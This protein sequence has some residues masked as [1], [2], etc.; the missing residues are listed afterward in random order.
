MNFIYGTPR[1]TLERLYRQP[2]TQLFNTD[3]L[4]ALSAPSGQFTTPIFE[5]I[6]ED[7]IRFAD[8]ALLAMHENSLNLSTLDK[9]SLERSADPEIHSDVEFYHLAHENHMMSSATLEAL[10]KMVTKG[11]KFSSS[12]IAK[13]MMKLLNEKQLKLSKNG[14]LMNPESLKLFR[15]N[16]E[17]IESL[18]I[19]NYEKAIRKLELHNLEAQIQIAADDAMVKSGI[20]LI[21]YALDLIGEVADESE[22]H[23][24]QV[25][26]KLAQYSKLTNDFQLDDMETQLIA[27]GLAEEISSF[28]FVDDT[29]STSSKQNSLIKTLSHPAII[30]SLRNGHI[31]SVSNLITAFNQNQSIDWTDQNNILTQLKLKPITINLLNIAADSKDLTPAQAQNISSLAASVLLTDG[32]SQL[33]AKL[34]GHELISPLLREKDIP[35]TEGELNDLSSALK[36]YKNLSFISGSQDNVVSIINNRQTS[37]KDLVDFYSS[38]NQLSTYPE[39]TMALANRI[40][41]TGHRIRLLKSLSNSELSSFLENHLDAADSKEQSIENLTIISKIVETRLDEYENIKHTLDHFDMSKYEPLMDLGN[42]ADAISNSSISKLSNAI[43]I[44]DLNTSLLVDSYINYPG[45][46]LDDLVERGTFREATDVLSTHFNNKNPN[47]SV[48][49]INNVTSMRSAVNNWLTTGQNLSEL[50]IKPENAA[51]LVKHIAKEAVKNYKDGEFKNTLDLN[52][53]TAATLVQGLSIE[54][55]EDALFSMHT[56]AQEKLL[57]LSYALE[58]SDVEHPNYNQDIPNSNEASIVNLYSSLAYD[59]AMNPET[60]PEAIAA[61]SATSYIVENRSFNTRIKG[62]FAEPIDTLKAALSNSLAH[63]KSV[64]TKVLKK[65]DPLSLSNNLAIPFAIDYL[66]IK[67][68]EQ[69]ISPNSLVPEELEEKLTESQRDNIVHLA[70]ILSNPNY[71]ATDLDSQ[72][73]EDLE[74]SYHSIPSELTIISSATCS[75]EIKKIAMNVYLENQND[76]YSRVKAF[77][78]ILEGCNDH[79]S[80]LAK[81]LIANLVKDKRNQVDFLEETAKSFLDANTS[82]KVAVQ[83]SACLENIA[84][85]EQDIF[86]NI[87]D[88]VRD[89]SALNQVSPLMKDH[90]NDVLSVSKN[91]APKDPAPTSTIKI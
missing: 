47:P 3:E 60:S 17:D 64:N 25:G 4:R 46:R 32:N 52:P 56:I 39:I 26:H 70:G 81:N 53:K 88:E 33:K 35:F 15:K 86:K 67:S 51:D 72:T 29:I 89:S 54:D 68:L 21:T 42:A 82:M 27:N 49:R 20:K 59:L 37:V 50:K 41:S 78:A 19:K 24:N 58:E 11:S 55:K 23:N 34:L 36:D 83:M 65:T 77:K 57:G 18:N 48:D 12:V 38:N 13:K 5:M 40:D 6:E 84:P 91:L 85:K 69:G 28:E 10:E 63:P 75:D 22:Y 9:I 30:R 45:A 14:H 80:P 87:M 66:K 73:I 1:I 71:N 2:I 76:P 74:E 79:S 8:G 31:D 7:E 61:I 44:S 16:Q 62:D 90:V 43:D